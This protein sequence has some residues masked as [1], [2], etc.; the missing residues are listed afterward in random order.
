[1]SNAN[2]PTYPCWNAKADDDWH[3][4]TKREYFALELTKVWVSVLGMGPLVEPPIEHIR[5]A[6][7]RGTYQADMLLAELE[8]RG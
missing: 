1:M 2:E 6:N 7:R 3:G 8:K 4:L 5:E